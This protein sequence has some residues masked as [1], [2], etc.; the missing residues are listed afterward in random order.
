MKYYYFN[1]VLIILKELGS[2][3][4]LKLN[5]SNPAS[6]PID[7]PEWCWVARLRKQMY[8]LSLTQS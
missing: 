2:L 1:R 3:K 6:Y 5:R 8:F 4:E 7:R